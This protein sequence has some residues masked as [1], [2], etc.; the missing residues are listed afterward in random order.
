M[1]K[2]LVDY[3]YLFFWFTGLISFIMLVYKILTT[4]DNSLFLGAFA[5]L[6]SA[7]LASLSM[8]KSINNA[9]EIEKKKIDSDKE[10]LILHLEYILLDLLDKTQQ[11]QRDFP[12]FVDRT[13]KLQKDSN[14]NTFSDDDS[15][16]T[17]QE[18]IKNTIK[19]ANNFFIGTMVERKRQFSQ[20]KIEL[21]NPNIYKYLEDGNRMLLIY[22]C[23]KISELEMFLDLLEKSQV[24]AIVESMKQTIDNLCSSLIE[25]IKLQKTD[26]EK[27][28]PTQSLFTIE[29]YEEFINRI[30]EKQ[31]N[32]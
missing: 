24:I 18:D 15:I 3:I 17:L 5:I 2:K 1:L 26:L 25:L 32:V 20:R 16:V 31:A 22:I 14:I 4:S 30:T 9:K 28:H 29:E 7:F 6:I 12:K 27:N 10:T 23:L 21:E 19:S 11:F 8:I 13:L